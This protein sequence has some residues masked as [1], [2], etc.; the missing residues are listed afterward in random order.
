MSR[1]RVRV[2]PTI[3]ASQRASWENLKSGNGRASGLAFSAYASGAQAL[4]RRCRVP[5]GRTVPDFFPFVASMHA[6]AFA[7]LAGG[8]GGAVIFSC[9]RFTGF[10]LVFMAAARVRAPASRQAGVRAHGGAARTR[11][12]VEPENPCGPKA[13]ILR[14]ALWNP[15]PKRPFSASPEPLDAQSSPS[16]IPG[17]KPPLPRCRSATHLSLGDASDLPPPLPKSTTSSSLCCILIQPKSHQFR[18]GLVYKQIK[19]RP[20]VLPNASASSARRL[21]VARPL[22]A[23]TGDLR[24][25]KSGHCAR[26]VCLIG[27]SFRW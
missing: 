19:Q 25:S 11:E 22:H 5:A 2:S 8:G 17:P 15:Q 4:N 23:A 9:S 21:I 20:P 16:R 1:I 3:I 26:P 14:P 27:M 12:P 6:S 7:C 13:V 10:G 24:G 18:L